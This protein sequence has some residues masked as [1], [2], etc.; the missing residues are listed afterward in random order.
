MFRKRLHSSP[1]LGKDIWVTN[2]RPDA[3]IKDAEID[4]SGLTVY[5]EDEIALMR[6]LPSSVVACAARGIDIVKL[7]FGR[8]SEV[9]YCGPE[10]PRGTCKAPLTEEDRKLIKRRGL[11]KPK[12]EVVVP[13]GHM[14]LRK[15]ANKADRKKNFS[16]FDKK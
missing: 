14:K 15:R 12:V 9:E 6:K 10:K 5:S 8:A 7:V 3:A 4:V 13:P 16:L 11:H 1:S 2:L